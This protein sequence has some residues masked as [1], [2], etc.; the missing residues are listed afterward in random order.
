MGEGVGGVGEGEALGHLVPYH[1]HTF[2]REEAHLEAPLPPPPYGLFWPGHV[3]HR[4]PVT[5]L[6]HEWIMLVKFGIALYFINV[7][8]CDL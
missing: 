2:T 7:T 3:Y 6:K 4:N 8:L 5:H 1:L